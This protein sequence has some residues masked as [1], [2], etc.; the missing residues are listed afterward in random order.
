VPL[1]V[2][3]SIAMTSIGEVFVLP[4]VAAGVVGAASFPGGGT[5]RRGF[6]LLRASV[7]VGT[8]RAS[9]YESPGGMHRFRGA[10]GCRPPVLL[11]RL[12]T[13]DLPQFLGSGQDSCIIADMVA[14]GR[15]EST[16][17]GSRC[18]AYGPRL[19]ACADGRGNPR[20]LV[21][22]LIPDFREQSGQMV[23]RATVSI[24]TSPMPET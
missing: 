23:C 2:R 21:R 16:A 24:S 11:G 3:S 7:L 17:C 6:L 4:N 13:G 9:L 14:G 22:A 10:L 18:A 19:T 20:A 8:H 5:G 15:Q 12:G 1:L